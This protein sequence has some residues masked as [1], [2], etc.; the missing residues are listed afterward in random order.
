LVLPLCEMQPPKKPLVTD[1]EQ[2]FRWTAATQ[3]D[4]YRFFP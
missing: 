3:R 1:S 2:M 4:S